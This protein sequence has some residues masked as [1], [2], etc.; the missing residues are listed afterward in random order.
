MGIALE[1]CSLCHEEW[2]DP[3]AENGACKNCRK[4]PKFQ[5]SNNMYS[6]NEASHLPELI[7]MEE[8]LISPLHLMKPQRMSILQH[9]KKSS[10][11][12]WKDTKRGQLH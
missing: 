5:P 6:G 11:E 2:L 7:Q 9:L 10:E 8:M 12:C 3:E 1:S 4:S